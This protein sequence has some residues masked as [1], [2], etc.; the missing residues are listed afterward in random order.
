MRKIFLLLA[1]CLVFAGCDD[2]KPKPDQ[3]QDQ[4]SE[5]EQKE[6]EEEEWLTIGPR[7]DYEA[8]TG[9]FTNVDADEP[10]AIEADVERNAIF[11]VL[12]DING[13][14]KWSPDE[15]NALE[16]KPV[17]DFMQGEYHVLAGRKS[18]L[19]IEGGDEFNFDCFIVVFEERRNYQEWFCEDLTEYYQSEYPDAGVRSVARVTICEK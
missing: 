8:V 11:S 10:E 4:N 2:S 16:F 15:E 6:G 17:Y 12:D 9:V 7:Q 5:L 18:V 3:K 19:T 14:G 13:A 1:M